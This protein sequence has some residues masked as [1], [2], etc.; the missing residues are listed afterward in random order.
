MLVTIRM[1]IAVVPIGIVSLAKHYPAME[2]VNP[3]KIKDY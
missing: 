2:Y 3:N 1:A